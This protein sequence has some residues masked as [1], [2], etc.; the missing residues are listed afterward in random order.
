VARRP[1]LDLLL[2]APVAII[3]WDMARFSRTPFE[4]AFWMEAPA[5]L[6]RA[7]EFEH[8]L[9]PPVQYVHRDWA[10]PILLAM[11]AN[12]GVI[13]CYG[14]DPSFKPRAIAKESP[15]YRGLAWVAEGEGQARVVEW[16]TN[17]AVVEVTGARPGTL[18]AYD[19]NYDSSWRADG[20][21]ALDH[22]GIVAGRLR[23]GS[24]RIEFSYFP[25]T[26]AGS[27][28]LFLATL[29][30]CFWRRRYWPG[31]RASALRIGRLARF[32]ARS[33]DPGRAAGRP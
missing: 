8:R 3:A 15:E 22:D 32:R 33:G 29:A 10:A 19:M 18:V 2:L 14:F 9:N 25:R 30:A 1:W 4:Q 13:R 21:N 23:A 26:L 6:R 17:R 5:D 7:P 12:R 11:F 20:E 27:V 24:N 16:T 28:P 31:L